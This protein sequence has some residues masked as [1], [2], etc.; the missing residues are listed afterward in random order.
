MI[1]LISDYHTGKTLS[2]QFQ[3]CFPVHHKKLLKLNE[4]QSIT[5]K[6]STIFREKSHQGML[7]SRWD[8]SIHQG[9]FVWYHLDNIKNR[10]VK[11]R[12]SPGNINYSKF[13]PGSTNYVLYIGEVENSNFFSGELFYRP[14]VFRGALRGEFSRGQWDRVLYR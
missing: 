5:K 12:K 8:P 13:P 2:K 10:W 4:N 11:F 1:S 6:F 9:L 7:W 3:L 14:D